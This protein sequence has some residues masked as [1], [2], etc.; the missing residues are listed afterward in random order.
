ME[1]G[2]LAL[3][4]Q[5]VSL[6]QADTWI[7]TMELNGVLSDEQ[8]GITLHTFLCMNKLKMKTASL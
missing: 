5:S 3:P 1:T 8:V 4:K 6:E 7:F 2:H